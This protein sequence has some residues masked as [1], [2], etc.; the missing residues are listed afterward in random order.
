[1]ESLKKPK[2]TSPLKSNSWI[3]H[4]SI[5]GF[6]NSIERKGE[7]LSKVI[8]DQFSNCL[9]HYNSQYKH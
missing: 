5:S 2:K 8:I 7:N 9:E 3:T 1:M 4:E 6:L